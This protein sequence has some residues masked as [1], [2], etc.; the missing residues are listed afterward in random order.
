MI[1]FVIP[2]YGSQDTLT[3]VVEEICILMKSADR[4]DF[5]VIL[6]NDN[7]PDDVYS[8]IQTLAKKNDKIKVINLAK[9]FGQH[10]AL[11]AGYRCALGEIIVS[12]D[13][14]GQI[15]IEETFKLISKIE[16][17]FDVAYANYPDCKRGLFRALGS[18]INDVMAQIIL[19]K[20]KEIQMTSF[21]A[22]KKFI[23]TQMSN[24]D[25]PYPYLSGL[26]LAATKN[27]TS[28]PVN[29]RERASGKSGYTL[30]KLFSL[31]LN[32]F[33]AFSVKPLRIAS[34]LGFIC[35][36]LGFAYGIYTVINRFINPNVPMGYSSMMAAILFVGGMIMLML[37]LIGEYVGRI[38]ISIN[39]S[40]QYVIKETINIDL[41][42]KRT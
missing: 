32:G 31:W 7:S 27:I 37:G 6:V 36:T 8:V 18:K 11:M 13:D 5:E 42:E 12:V 1:S 2:C 16:E 22:M 38:Y 30:R 4:H 21:Y 40:P 23:A 15:P 10:A 29:L 20:P 39:N 28:V 34:V 26:I 35:A 33:T 9:N 3:S 19:S 41:K 14:D 25:N 17:G 24:Y